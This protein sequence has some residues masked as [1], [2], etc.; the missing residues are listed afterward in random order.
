MP[1]L[2][3]LV[4]AVLM[5]LAAAPMASASDSLFS[6]DEQAESQERDHDDKKSK[7]DKKNKKPKSNNGKRHAY[8]KTGDAPGHQD[9]DRSDDDRSDDDDSDDRSDDDESDDGPTP[10]NTPP[11]ASLVGGGSVDVGAVVGLDASGSS[12]ADGDALSY[13]WSIDQAP[14]TSTAG[15]VGSGSAVTI[16]PDVEGAYVV[17][18]SVSDGSATATASV[19]LDASIPNGAPVAVDDSYAVVEGN[20]LSAGMGGFF[21]HPGVLNNDSDP[22]GDPLSASLESG[23]MF[24]TITFNADGSFTYTP[25]AGFAG[26]DT[27]TYRVSDGSSSAVGVV[28]IQVIDLP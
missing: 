11:V 21:G 25:N 4:V 3:A 23:P 15:I 22:E 12:D 20:V 6:E 13:L 1:R 18:V 2:I 19:T 10:T 24:G 14:V 8:G 26:V 17:T 9:D 7:K 5:L 16:M 27:F 28:S